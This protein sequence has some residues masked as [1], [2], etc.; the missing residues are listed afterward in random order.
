MGLVGAAHVQRAHQEDPGP[1]ANVRAQGLELLCKGEDAGL[2]EGAVF[3]ER[4]AGVVA[5][6]V[7]PDAGEMRRQSGTGRHVAHELGER[8]DLCAVAQLQEAG[9][10]AVEGLGFLG[11]VRLS[12]QGAQ[13]GPTPVA[14]VLQ[15]PLAGPHGRAE[16]HREDLPAQVEQP[17]RH[18]VHRSQAVAAGCAS[19]RACGIGGHAQIGRAGGEVLVEG[20][21]EDP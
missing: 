4:V 2:L 6:Q 7:G 16:I 13:V 11:L 17:L 20:L 15:E 8:V 21:A 19:E 14:R 10:A 9:E 12:V 3:L 18:G 5:I 1:A